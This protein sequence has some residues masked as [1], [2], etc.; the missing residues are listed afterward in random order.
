MVLITVISFPVVLVA[1]LYSLSTMLTTSQLKG[2]TPQQWDIV[3]FSIGTLVGILV[4][5]CVMASYV[6]FTKIMYPLGQA[7]SVTIG[8]Q[9]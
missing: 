5:G 4:V 6:G 8:P 7:Q 1:A 3:T 2:L 9:E